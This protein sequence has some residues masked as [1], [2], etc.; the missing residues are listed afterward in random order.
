MVITGG[1]PMLQLDRALVD[2]LHD[3]GFRVAVESN[4]T[5]PA[6]ERH[7]LA[8]HQPEGGDRG[9]PAQRRRAEAGLAAGRESILQSS[10]SWD[11]DH[12]LVQ[13][14]D[15]EERERSAG[16]GDRAGDGAAALAAV[17][18]GAQAGRTALTQA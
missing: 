9:R 12:F 14:M 3:R 17:A 10:K 15:C 5:L 2:A 7:R 6:V 18:A 16:G 8:V 11:F 4:G 13:P 1:E